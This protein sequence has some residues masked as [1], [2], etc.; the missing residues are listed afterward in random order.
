MP[1]LVKYSTTN[2]N[3]TIRKGN[4]SIGI[5]AVDYGP[6]STS[7]FWNV[8]TTQ[9]S[10]YLVCTV[11]SNSNTPSVVSLGSDSQMITYARVLGGTN[12]NTIVD[13][14]SYVCG[15][16][17]TVVF[18][19]TYTNIVTD[20][21]V[22]NL[23]ANSTLSYPRGNT[24]WYDVSGNV[25][26]STLTNGPTFSEGYITFD[27]ADDY[28]NFSAGTLSNTVTVEMICRIGSGYNGKMFFGW[29]NYDVWCGGGHLGYNTGNGDVY[30][31]SS[32]QVSTLGLVNNWK[33]YV[34]EM[35]DNV[36]YT[37]NKIYV[38]GVQ[39][40][41]SQQQSTENPGGRSF[42]SG[43]GRIALWLASAGYEMPMNLRSFRV[44]NKALSTS[45]INQNLYNGG[46]VT[47]NLSH[48]WDSSNFL[49][50]S[51]S[52]TPVYDFVGNVNGTLTNG[53]VFNTG[54]NGHWTFDGSNDYLLLNNGN[55]SITLGNG[56]TDWT[57]NIWMKTTTSSNGLSSNG[58]LLSNTNGGPIYSAFSVNAGKQTYWAYPSNINNW[59]QFQGTI[60]VNDGEWHML[61]WV[62]N[63]N[64]NMD[65]YVDG[66]YDTT[67]S[68]VNVANNN[69]LDI[70]GGGLGFISFNGS[71]GSVQ[72]N[73][74]TAFNRNQVIQQ[75][76][77]TQSKFKR[78]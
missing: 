64:Y 19:N 44:Y 34:F 63:S 62:N 42:N 35:R 22:L 11:P 72:I 5:N 3:N 39:Q 47:T 13:A 8:G 43:N 69:P 68:P 33:H 67:V 41:L 59:K 53:P 23:D 75:Y 36:S 51:G 4:V 46:I 58:D 17:N 32:T 15:L 66:K 57:V 10:G 28:S 18:N 26:N 29:S 25:R 1:N 24:T 2:V 20:S 52:S 78:N 40:T 73:K 61:T 60:N 9:N 48:L 37:N 71:I 76:A 65:L 14:L 30:G 12:I 54:A 27:G 49:S 6:T 56:N 7:G 38:N 70:I 31:I 45:E 55:Y 21:L 50:Y 74:G 16:T 77:A